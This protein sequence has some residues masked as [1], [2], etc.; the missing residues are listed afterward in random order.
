MVAS[1]WEIGRLG[2]YGSEHLEGL[3]SLVLEIW[4]LW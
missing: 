2:L 4:T 1:G 3:R